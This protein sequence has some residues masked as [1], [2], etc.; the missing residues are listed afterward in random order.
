VDILLRGNCREPARQAD[1]TTE[2]AAA[3][4]VA[5]QSLGFLLSVLAYPVAVAG[6]IYTFCGAGFYHG[7]D[8]ARHLAVWMGEDGVDEDWLDEN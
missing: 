5:Q 2:T 1:M 4:F 7:V 3:K 8:I 6:F